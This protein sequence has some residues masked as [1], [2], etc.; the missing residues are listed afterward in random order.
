VVRREFC[1]ALMGVQRSCC[2][3][4]AKMAENTASP[5]WCSCRTIV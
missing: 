5:G 1:P 4:N 2:L 3:M